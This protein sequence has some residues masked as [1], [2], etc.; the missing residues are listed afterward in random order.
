MRPAVASV[1]GISERQGAMRETRLWTLDDGEDD[2][3]DRRD[4]DDPQQE[5]SLLTSTKDL[6]LDVNFDLGDRPLPPT[7]AQESAAATSGLCWACASLA[8]LLFLLSVVALGAV[9]ERVR[10]DGQHHVRQ[11]A[12][13][14]VEVAATGASE[15][16]LDAI[17]LLI[18]ASGREKNV[19]ACSETKSN[20]TFGE[21]YEEDLEL[22]LVVFKQ[23]PAGETTLRLPCDSD[24]LGGGW[25]VVQRRG[26]YENPPN[27]FDRT[28]PD[29]LRGFGDPAGEFWLG[30]ET[31][32]ALTAAEPHELL[33]VV[34]DEQGT[35]RYARYRHFH[36]SADGQYSLHVDGYSG[37]AGDGLLASSGL[38]FSTMDADRDGSFFRHCAKER[39]GGWW[40][41]GQ[42]GVCTSA[43]NLNGLSFRGPIC[44]SSECKPERGVV[45]PAARREQRG[46]WRPP[47]QTPMTTRTWTK[48]RM[49]I[50][51][52]RYSVGVD[53]GGMAS[54]EISTAPFPSINVEK[55]AENQSENTTLGE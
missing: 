38:A 28:L 12:N 22:S 13:I 48:A 41:S 21:T 54:M 10:D 50:R 37:N 49:M 19:K 33:V 52:T 42:G 4:E 15:I 3:D 39:S 23:G 25:L 1:V 2:D 43:A 32:R 36:L 44:P 55:K 20:V 34:A 11:S 16:D 26:H 9:V 47:E 18:L 17:N 5:E 7:P 53:D 45:W 29:Y 8:L 51:P 31:L 40:H 35:V 27:F 6:A 30:L 46:L 24:T 14:E